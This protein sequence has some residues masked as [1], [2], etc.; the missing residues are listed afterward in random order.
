MKRL[1]LAMI[2]AVSFSNCSATAATAFLQGVSNA[3]SGR[4]TQLPSGIMIFGGPNR[5]VFLGCL[6]CQPTDPAS[7]LNDFGQYG[8]PFSGDSLRNGFS[9][10]GNRFNPNSP[11]NEFSLSAPV[12][13]DGDG[14]YYG[15]LTMNKSNPRRTQLRAALVWLAVT[16][17]EQ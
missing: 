15:E 2:A 6:T 5:D 4:P 13:V 12:L 14:N 17:A 9:T 1:A 8:N 7:V 11:C 3:Q 16:C 10:Y